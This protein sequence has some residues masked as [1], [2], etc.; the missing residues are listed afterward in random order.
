MTPDLTTPAAR[1]LL[2]RS[3]AEVRGAATGSAILKELLSC[4]DMPASLLGGKRV[5]SQACG[6]LR[7]SL[8]TLPPEARPSIRGCIRELRW[9]LHHA[10]DLATLLF[11]NDEDRQL[12]LRCSGR[13]PYLLHGARD[14]GLC[15]LLW[16]QYSRQGS[17]SLD[18]LP[19]LQRPYD[20]LRREALLT[21][22]AALNYWSR[23]K[24]WLSPVGPRNIVRGAMYRRTLAIRHFTM[25][26]YRQRMG[27]RDVLRC[28]PTAASRPA[29]RTAL[30]QSWRK[31]PTS[32]TEERR[33]SEDLGSI[34]SLLRVADDPTS[35]HTYTKTAEVEEPSDEV[36]CEVERPDDA[37]EQADEPGDG[38][39]IV[40]STEDEKRNYEHDDLNAQGVI[41]TRR[42]WSTAAQNDC[43]EAGIHP[44]D[45]L[46]IE[47]LHL[48]ARRN[49]NGLAWEAMHNQNLSLAWRNLAMEEL[50]VALQIL[51]TQADRGLK[52]LEIFALVKI[53]AARGL[54]LP[55]AQS[56]D[57]R[58]DRPDEVKTLTLFLLANTEQAEWLVPPVQI[59][60]QQEHGTYPG[61]RQVVK[62]FVLPD[63]WNIGNLLR[64]LMSMK[65]P[66]WEGELLQPFAAPARLEERPAT[67]AQRLSDALR[68]SDSDRG[69]GLAD[70]VTFPRIG[71]VLPQRIYD[72]TAGN[73]VLTTYATL[74][75][76]PTGEDGR[77]YA[78]PAVLSVQRADL[79][80]TSSIAEE[81][82]VVGYNASMDPALKPSSSSG[83]LGSPMC[84]TLK[85]VETFVAKLVATIA[86]AN[87]R[88]SAQVDIEA[89]VA[90]H[91]A[92]TMLTFCAV[93]LG[94]CH[95]PTH[96]A[97]P[98]LTEIDTSTG[99][100]S[101]VDK[102]SSKARLGVAAESSVAQLRAYGSYTKSFAFETYFGARP[103]LS[104]FFIG[105]KAE[106]LAVSPATLKQQSLPFVANFARHLVKTTLSEWC[107]SGDA[108]VSEE[109]IAA[110][111]GHFFAGEEPFGAYSSFG[112]KKFAH[113][114]RA[115]L[116]DQLTAVGF[117]PIDIHGERFTVYAS[118]I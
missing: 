30:R 33:L 3:K 45:A 77:F 106:F 29:I 107:E 55:T 89:I 36:V 58:G 78:T 16:A 86:A 68:K 83:Y 117:S 42:R 66:G 92:F 99:M 53:V 105:P 10:E 23:R 70:R 7:E 94:T 41:Y 90:R 85:A 14:H 115:V 38:R 31:L 4:L 50:G 96:G 73:L 116:G 63:Y 47:N 113:S 111:L 81:L 15:C 39:Q 65:F 118:Q 43:I 61:C 1:L 46:P 67:Y 112:Y 22:I 69:P 25:D 51:E 108:R 54:T 19:S 34:L 93:S 24:D 60:Y 5:A 102:G 101:L 20:A 114:M 9:V 49:G 13:N 21:Q 91:N 72:Q 97:I 76:N 95:R 88:L 52:E 27:H 109:W 100:V 84:P 48:S 64:R 103:E 37:D 26:S 74:Q 35:I 40:E 2:V 104:F 56:I 6:L 62:S 79:A 17:Q 71:R 11:D 18:E 75:K 98:D 32:R 80:A 44:A 82:R 57:V 87:H 28:I 110:F 12:F 8:H 59:P